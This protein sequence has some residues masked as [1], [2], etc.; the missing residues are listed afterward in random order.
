MNGGL[1]PGVE[2]SLDPS[3]LEGDHEDHSL[4]LPPLAALGHISNGLCGSPDVTSFVKF[5]DPPVSYQGPN[6]GR[7]VSVPPPRALL[8]RPI[9]TH[10]VI[11]PPSWT[12]CAML[13]TFS[14]GACYLTTTVTDLPPS[15]AVLD[16]VTA[17][18]PD[19][20][21]PERCNADTPAE[22]SDDPHSGAQRWTGVPNT[23]LMRGPETVHTGGL[24][25]L[26][27]ALSNI[28]PTDLHLGDDPSLQP[29]P[30][31]ALNVVG[32]SGED[33]DEPGILLESPMDL[34]IVPHLE[35]C[36][37]V[38][39]P[40]PIPS[41][42]TLPRVLVTGGGGVVGGPQGV[43]EDIRSVKDPSVPTPETSKKQ[44]VEEKVLSC[45][46]RHEYPRVMLM[47]SMTIVGKEKEK[48]HRGEIS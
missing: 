26:F 18:H 27:M 10:S 37:P 44:D 28:A 17:T 19:R 46:S 34:R 14:G 30:V 47:D 21:G 16:M 20:Q 42:A 24:N 48:E 13:A 33:C 6:P 41:G 32:R 31:V 15:S 5:E 9:S 23:V 36:W 1:N 35:P 45:S 38:Q 29:G 2:P 8:P 3:G 22:M 40:V 4:V 7:T 12:E 11:V 25:T 43:E 39:P